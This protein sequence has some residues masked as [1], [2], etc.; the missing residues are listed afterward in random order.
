MD[1]QSKKRRIP[2]KEESDAF[3]KGVDKAM[4]CAAI[5]ARKRAIQNQGYVETW[6]DGMLVR[7]TE[8]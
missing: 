6:R 4:R 1:R 5:E 2:T 7:D 8:V 3:L